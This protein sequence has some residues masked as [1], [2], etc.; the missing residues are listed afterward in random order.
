MNRHNITRCAAAG[1]VAALTLTGCNV[2]PNVASKRTFQVQEDLTVVDPSLPD[3]SEKFSEEEGHA[4]ASAGE[5]SLSEASEEGS[6]D[7]DISES[8]SEAAGESIS[9]AVEA[10]TEAE[11]AVSEAVQDEEGSSEPSTPVSKAWHELSLGAQ[12]LTNMPLLPFTLFSYPEKNFTQLESR[13]NSILSEY[14][15][16]WSVSVIDLSS[17]ER[18]LIGDQP[19]KSASTMKLFIMAAVYDAI[20][21]GDLDRTEEIVSLLTN[22]I[23][24]SSNEAANRLL[25]ALGGGDYNTGIAKVNNYIRSNGFSSETIEYNGF[26]DS[27]AIMDSSHFNTITAKDVSEL[28]YRIYHRTFGRRR[29]CEE[30]ENW[31]L[32]Q[33]TRYKIPAGISDENVQI[34]NKTGETDDTENDC[35]F[36]YT[37]EGDY[38]LCVFSHDWSSKDAAQHGI[39]RISTAVY[40]YFCTN[41]IED[42]EATLIPPVL[43]NIPD[44][45]WAE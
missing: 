33:Q 30:V 6:S 11:E 17:D 20:D 26:Q 16:S 3:L 2:A 1:C 34:A 41:A 12:T 15:G 22:M 38:I 23:T 25:L 8:I 7:L 39:Q 43:M 13:L 28:M 21:K 19:M 40:E 42:F 35:A 18:L 37:P 45:T 31:M 10:V 36:V 44:T 14:D 32:N 24:V 27:S 5:E 29:I 4:D 9:E